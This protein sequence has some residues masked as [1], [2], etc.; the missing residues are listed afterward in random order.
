V[1]KKI[2]KRPHREGSFSLG[3]FNV[4]LDCFC[5]VLIRMLVDSMQRNPDAR[6]TG[7]GAWRR[8]EKSRCHPP[9]E[10]PSRGDLTTI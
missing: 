9:Q 6:A 3:K 7:N 2:D 8:A 4:K 10:S 5:G 1:D